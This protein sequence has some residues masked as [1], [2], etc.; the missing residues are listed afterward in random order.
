MQAVPHAAAV[1]AGQRQR[2]PLDHH[3]LLEPL[4]QHPGRERTRHAG[5]GNGSLVPAYVRHR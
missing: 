3:H 2:V 1:L 5:T 4:R